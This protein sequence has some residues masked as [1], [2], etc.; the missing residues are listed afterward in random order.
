MVVVVVVVLNK[1]LIK[2]VPKKIKENVGNN[3]GELVIL[4]LKQLKYKSKQ[5]SLS[6]L[7]QWIVTVTILSSFSVGAF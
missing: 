6:L 4:L 5:M 1:T 3:R 7:K 2:T